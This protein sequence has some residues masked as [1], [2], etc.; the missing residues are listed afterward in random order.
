MKN[1][2]AGLGALLAMTLWSPLQA[3]A[4]LD[5][6][7]TSGAN[8]QTIPVFW[9][10]GEEYVAGTPGERYSVRLANRSSERVLAVVSVDGVNAVSGETAGVGQA[11]YVLDPWQTMEVKGWRK[12]TADVARFYFTRLPDS[13][14]ARTGRP[15]NVGVIGVAV[16]REQSA[17]SSVAPAPAA[18]LRGPSPRADSIPSGDAPSA[19]QAPS[20]LPRADGSSAADRAASAG[21][22]ERLVAP[23]PPRVADATPL[24]TGHGERQSAP[25]RLVAFQRAQDTPDEVHTIWYDSKEALVRRGI[26]AESWP[27]PR[28]PEPFPGTFVPDPPCCR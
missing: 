11:G 23:A 15:A 20:A 21:L 13:Y 17:V 27:V 18:P 9:N 1:L 16:F 7:V 14:A 2:V 10:R 12:S 24:G 26:I 25:V 4:L 22:A 8:G 19:Q 5:V 6:A 3:Q 28:R